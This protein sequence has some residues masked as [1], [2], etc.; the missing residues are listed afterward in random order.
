MKTIIVPTDFSSTADNAMHYAAML[1]NELNAGI[2]LVHIYTVPVT[3][4]D[5]PVMMISAEELKHGADDGLERCKAE[6]QKES[7]GLPVKTESRLGDL[8]SELEDICK[9]VDPLFIVMGTHGGS[10]FEQLM[11]GSSAWSAIKNISYPII[12]VPANYKH[13]NHH[14]IVLA[15]DMDEVQTKTMQQIMNVVQLLNAKLHVVHVKVD[16]EEDDGVLPPLIHQLSPVAPTYHLIEDE[17]I[18]DALNSYIKNV[19]AGLLIVLP[20]EHNLIESLF[21]KMHTKDLVRNSPVPVL[22]I[23]S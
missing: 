7:E 2:L 18:N 13:T 3:M 20:H 14:N 1:A 11:F 12:A 23:R 6:I 15:A 22:C 9:D 10:N 8:V 19:A 4:N 17:N 5:M 21:F 16:K